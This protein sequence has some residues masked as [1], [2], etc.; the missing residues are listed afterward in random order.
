[1]SRLEGD[2][3]SL[4]L[5]DFLRFNAVLSRSRE[6]RETV[7][8]QET[9]ELDGEGIPDGMTVGRRKSVQNQLLDVKLDI[10]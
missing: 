10:R 9:L 5:L 2:R 4:D 6:P 1:L 3:A 7:G 8:L